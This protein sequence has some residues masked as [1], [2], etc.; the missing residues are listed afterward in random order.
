MI[1]QFGGLEVSTSSTTPAG[2]HRRRALPHRLPATSRP[3]A[4]PPSCWRSRRCA[5][6][7]TRSTR[8]ELPSAGEIDAAMDDYIAELT[9]MQ[10]DDG[11]FPY[12]SRGRPSEP[13]NTIHA[14]HALIVARR[15]RVRGAG[16]RD[17]SRRRRARQ[18][19]SSSSP[20]SSTSRRSWTLRAYALHVR[21]L[22]GQ[23]RPGRGAGAVRRSRRRAT[24]RRARL[25]VA[26]DR[27]RRHRRGDR[28]APRQRRRRH[29]RRG[30]VHHR[31]QRRRGRRSRSPR[32]GAPTG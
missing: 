24:A 20:P 4:S 18:R 16:R 13:F 11:G 22:A 19:S 14:T 1:P 6:C 12:W 28:A 15:R 25:V 30:D 10:N 2:A 29:R 17:R 32:T 27:R 31:H 21:A 5:T 8:P 3:T 23:R 26:G 7:S 9:A